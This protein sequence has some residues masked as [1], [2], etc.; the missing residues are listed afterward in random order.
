[1]TT[2]IYGVSDDLIEVDGDVR[3]ESNYYCGNSEHGS[4]LICSDGTVLEIRYGKAEMAIWGIQ[5]I[6]KGTL[7]D[8]F[9][10]CT[11]ESAAR[12]SDTVYFKD[13]LKWVY[14]AQKWEKIR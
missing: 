3:G 5:V 10:I 4:L 2:Q 13:G 12:Y 11:D 6:Q 1:M 8:S 9:D 7:F 14:A